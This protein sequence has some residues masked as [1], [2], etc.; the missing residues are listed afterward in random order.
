MQ[1]IE[2]TDELYGYLTAI[3]DTTGQTYDEI[4]RHW[5]DGRSGASSS[6]KASS[7]RPLVPGNGKAAAPNQRDSL[8]LSHV[9]S[10]S[11]LSLRSAVDQFLNVLSFV[12]AQNRD[13]F[14]M[15]ES[16][17]GRKRKYFAPSQKE[18]E[19]SGTSV[20]PKEIPGT[21]YF[22]VTNNDTNNKRLLLQR[23]LRLLRYSETTVRAVSGS[24]R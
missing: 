16:L 6:G 20:N 23:V 17:G 15:A 7:G 18:L 11:F 4:L 2:I 1:T 8:L 10:P 5:K 3:R 22:V 12:H 21:P 13:N 19:D 9:Q 24:I 14:K